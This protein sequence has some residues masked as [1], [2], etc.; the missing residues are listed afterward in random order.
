MADDILSQDSEQSLQRTIALLPSG[1]SEQHNG[2]WSG[3]VALTQPAGPTGP[4][5]T[6]Y[7][8][9]LRR[10]WLLSTGLGLACAA[11]A[12]GSLF[13]YLG[14]KYT[15]SA[16]IKVEMQ[17]RTVLGTSNSTD[18]ERFEIFKS[19]QREALLG[20][21]V[22]TA[23]LRKKEIAKIPVI[24][25]QT[26]NGDAPDWLQRHLSVDFPGKAEWMVVSIT[27]YD[28]REAAALVNAVVD[29]YYFDVVSVERS[30]KQNRVDRLESAVNAKEDEIRKARNEL[31]NLAKSYGI[32]ADNDAITQ[33]QRL[34]LDELGLYRQELARREFEAAK[35]DSELASQMA[36]LKYMDIADVPAGEVE[37]WV[38]KDQMAQ[39]LLHEL[40]LRKV[41][42]ITGENGGPPGGDKPPDAERVQRETKTLQDE[43][44]KR[45]EQLVAVARKQKRSV[46]QAEIIKLETTLKVVTEQRDNLAKDVEK[47]KTEAANFGVSSVE[48]EMLKSDLKQHE[49]VWTKLIDQRD[50]LK[51]ELNA[52]QRIG[53][54]QKAEPP[55][56]PS[57]RTSRLFMTVMATIAAFCCPVVV[58]MFWHVCTRRTRRVNVA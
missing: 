58:V 6:T 27:R 35:L 15:A 54:P 8:H 45:R 41:R 12:G 43:F 20:R 5:L 38:Q 47:R 29:S 32:S 30:E 50:I 26:L 42:Q 44:N 1:G 13:W 51:I 19:S 34:F 33:R 21:P 28:P 49:L 2:E 55:P 31:R 24:E 9:A 10:H 37:T 14:E 18:R 3:A 53:Q 22:M 52:S 7:V 56:A 4:E 57:N 25:E 46:L 48:I 39:V 16:T 36:L 11:L 40:A 17:E 23:A